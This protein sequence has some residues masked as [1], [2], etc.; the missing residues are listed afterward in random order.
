MCGSFVSEE[1]TNPKAEVV[2]NPTRA[3]R[4]AT[5]RRPRPGSLALT[6]RPGEVHGRPPMSDRGPRI[7][8][9]AAAIGFVLV[10]SANARYLTGLSQVLDPMIAMDPFY[11]DMARRPVAEIVHTDPSWGPLYA[12]WLAPFVSVLRDPLRVYFANVV[13]LSIA[14]STAIYLYLL[15]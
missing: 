1:S 10:L 12:L 13:A 3:A 15:L 5:C 4:H 9:S 7:E 11:I 6:A 8:R 14:V 2:S